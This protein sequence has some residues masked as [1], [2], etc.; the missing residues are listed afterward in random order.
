MTG[1]GVSRSPVAT[2]VPLVAIAGGAV[3]TVLAV[4]LVS[5]LAGSGADPGR[6]L[7]TAAAAAA[8]WMVLVLLAIAVWHVVLIASGRA[9]PP[10]GEIGQI[11]GV[12][13][14]Y[15]TPALLGLGILLGYLFFK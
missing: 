11:N 15:L 10:V 3:L 12:V 9:G 8:G 1:S 2:V 13:R 6:W 4:F 14:R 7:P 5:V